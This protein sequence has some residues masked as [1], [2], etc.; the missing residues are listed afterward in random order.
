MTIK[1]PPVYSRRLPLSPRRAAW[2]LGVALLTLVVLDAWVPSIRDRLEAAQYGTTS[3]ARLSNSDVFPLGSLVAYLREH[4]RGAR[5]RVAFFGD[6]VVWGYGVDDVDS[7]PSQFQLLA[8]DAQVFNL[9]VNLFSTPSSY[10]LATRIVDAIDVA[11]L[12]PADWPPQALLPRVLDLSDEETRRWGYPSSDRS[13]L[14]RLVNGLLGRWHLYRDAYRLQTGLWGTST[15]QFIYVNKSQA[16]AAA[17]GRY[18][19][20]REAARLRD[21]DSEYLRTWDVPPLIAESAARSDEV[22]D[23]LRF[24]QPALV[25]FAELF[26]SRRKPA[27]VIEI[28]DRHVVLDA[29]E[30]AAMNERFAPYVRFVLL[31]P[32]RRLIFDGLHFTPEGTATVATMLD[33]IRRADA[34]PGRAF[35]R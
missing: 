15:K 11:F 18:R 32:P 34:A 26:V 25:A 12:I 22:M 19:T 14:D 16:I 21:A 24:R 10:L 7:I 9:G 23:A 27:Y 29:R 1:D 33:R 3:I 6:S 17:L 30:R 35:V 28:S 31:A 5:P 8:S 2:R 20:P 4:P 13:A